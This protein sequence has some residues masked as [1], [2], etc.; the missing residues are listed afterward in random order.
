MKCREKKKRR[1]R[2]NRDWSTLAP[3]SRLL[4]F[5]RL[6]CSAPAR[7]PRTRMRRQNLRCRPPARFRFQF[8]WFLAWETRWLL[9]RTPRHVPPFIPNCMHF[10]DGRAG[11]VIALP[12][13][14]FFCVSALFVAPSI[15]AGGQRGSDREFRYHVI[16]QS[17]SCNLL[18]LTTL[19][20]LRELVSDAFPMLLF[21][22][23]VYLSFLDN[24]SGSRR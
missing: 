18:F 13:V 11:R 8:P 5:M 17:G 14:I 15:V 20:F 1:N 7:L 12:S 21:C 9:V 24:D 16:M 10:H 23:E 3:R 22:S 4:L 6:S 2:L 19:K